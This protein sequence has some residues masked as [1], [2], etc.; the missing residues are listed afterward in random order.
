MG[1]YRWLE[2]NTRR[3]AAGNQAVE[4]VLFKVVRKGSPKKRALQGE[5]VSDRA[6]S[7]R[8]LSGGKKLEAAFDKHVHDVDKVS[9]LHTQLLALSRE[10]RTKLRKMPVMQQEQFFGAQAYSKILSDECFT[11][12]AAL[13][14]EHETMQSAAAR[15]FARERLTYRRSAKGRM[16]RMRMLRVPRPIAHSNAQGIWRPLRAPSVYASEHRMHRRALQVS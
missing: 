12:D 5:G 16:G 11:A 13:D 4:A 1:R 2:K 7:K 3:L 15:R 6:V 14:I 10:E 8:R 9:T